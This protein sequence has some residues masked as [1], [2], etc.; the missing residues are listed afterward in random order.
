MKQ[1]LPK[2]GPAEKPSL[3]IDIAEK[4]AELEPI[5]TNEI[6]AYIKIGTEAAESSEN[7]ELYISTLYRVAKLFWRTDRDA[8]ALDYYEK[9]ATYAKEINSELLPEIWFYTGV[10]FF[11]RQE[12][13]SAISW[14]EQCI[15]NAKKR[16]LFII[17][18][19]CSNL[20]ANIHNAQGHP[21]LAIPLLKVAL[22]LEELA[23][24][25][26][27]IAAI[28]NNL[29]LSYSKTGLPDKAI[30]YYLK[31]LV[32]EEQIGNLEGK[33]IS[34]MNV[35]TIYF[36]ELLDTESAFN[37][38][39]EAINLAVDQSMYTALPILFVNKAGFYY[40]DGQVEASRLTYIKALE[41]SKN[42]NDIQNKVRAHLGLGNIYL[43]EEKVTHAGEQFRL[44]NQGAI[45]IN[46]DQEK[47]IAQIGLGESLV[48][49]GKAKEGIDYLSYALELAKKEGLITQLVRATIELSD[50]YEALG[51][52]QTASSY[53]REYILYK[54]QVNTERNKEAIALFKTRYETEKKEAEI[55]LL[56]KENELKDIER[57]KDKRIQFW[58]YS[59]IVMIGISVL[60]IL[61]R[62]FAQRRSKR[63]I[64]E[65]NKE[66]TDAYEQL[67]KVSLTDPLTNLANR[68]AM[69]QYLSDELD[70][71][72]R[73]QSPFTLVLVDI[74]YFKKLNDTYGHD[75]GDFVLVE[76]SKLM[77]SLVRKQDRVCR[78][79]G[80]EFLLLLPET[81]LDGAKVLAEKIRTAIMSQQLEFQEDVISKADSNYKTQKHELKVTVTM[82]I[83]EFNDGQMTLE[84]AIK[85]ADTKL[86]EGKE[87]G[88]NCVVG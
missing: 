21:T 46:S 62:Y 14:L 44:A 53:L 5:S 48:L 74:D 7:A 67:K 49:S 65:K 64:N 75:G 24:N 52:Y 15:A 73:K 84:K 2:V 68:R 1:R 88:R 61:N 35:A 47:I 40:D 12:F 83:S 26:R 20:L 38:L 85:V 54:E 17:L 18:P 33:V 69:R 9:A 71:F 72:E 45:Q 86:Y 34:L 10:L 28:A 77:A 57:K 58:L 55:A 80:E 70:R 56:K 4:I 82:G 51:D 32:I 43:A 41:F 13:N 30:E 27:G 63:I 78:W 59:F 11:E 79:G 87:Q 60:I 22:E 3:A 81:S 23:G 36:H 42:V 8:E 6:D 16:N 19:R 76:I 25:Q 31:S 29:G 39:D 37:Y 66:L 50:A